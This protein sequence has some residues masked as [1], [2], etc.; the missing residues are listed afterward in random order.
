MNDTIDYSFSFSYN[1]PGRKP[2]TPPDPELI[3]FDDCRVFQLPENHVL[4]RSKQTGKQTL[5]T[6][7]VLY[8]LHRCDAFRTLGQ[9]I[10][11][12]A[13]TI[14]ELHGQEAD[15]RQILTSVQ[16]A[17]L[18]VSAKTL[19]ASLTHG[20]ATPRK[21]QPLNICILTCERPEALE[22][23]LDS[24]HGH[25][26]LNAENEYFVIDDSRKKQSQSRNR[27]VVETFNQE[28]GTRV[29]YFGPD[30]Q[31]GFQQ[32]LVSSLP[33][34]EAAIDFLIGRYQIEQTPSYGRTRNIAL[35]LSVG[36]QLVLLDDDILY[37]KHL[38][39]KTATGASISSRP[40][41]AEFY[42][43]N[44]EWMSYASAD[45]DDPALEFSNL[46]GCTLEQALANLDLQQLAQ[47]S[48]TDLLQ[49]EMPVVQHKES[50]ILVV[51]CGSYGDPGMD[52]NGWLYEISPVAR[53]S[54]LRSEDFYQ[55]ARCRRNIWSGRHAIHFSPA[56]V[57]ISQM[58]GVDNH[59]LLPPFFPLFRNEDFLFGENLQFLHPNSLMVDLPWALPHLPLVERR[60]DKERISRPAN[61]G[62]LEFT[63]DHLAFKKSAYQ[64]TDPSLRLQAL[65]GLFVDLGTL[66]DASL[67][68]LIKNETCGL[69]SA[70]IQRLDKVLKEFPDAPAYWADDMRKAISANQRGLMEKIDDPFSYCLKDVAKSQRLQHARGLW[71]QFGRS[72][73][74]WE[75]IRRAAQ[76]IISN[77]GCT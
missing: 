37:H 41:E 58:T 40:R 71:L 64:S 62:M 33:G 23:L 4:I 51:G 46:L 48:L 45:K 57:L 52:S 74:A 15:I 61:Y 32:Q 60:W 76:K 63:A 39:P 18:M 43:D 66:D 65:S 26:G 20:I 77:N 14:P 72:L 6:N 34:H 47:E 11:H 28:H 70:R 7:D 12:L 21:P 44:Q 53:D 22:R 5:V 25:Y 31:S 27:L 13:A 19:T 10:S 24:M 68:L 1:Q 59:E 3:I 16:H 38:P 36:R 67:A 35:L 73:A 56:F 42:S 54:L 49:L 30:E 50:R 69:Q 9:H 8:A 17:G 75:D 2:A 29:N 55:E